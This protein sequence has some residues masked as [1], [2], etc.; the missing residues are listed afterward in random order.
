[1]SAPAG[2]QA[3][4][5]QQLKKPGF[6]AVVVVLILAEIVSAFELSMMYVTLPT[7]ITEFQVDA[8]TVAWVV[9][10]YLLVS[11][12]AGVMGGRFGDLYGR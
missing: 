9:T 11:A 10:A 2:R 7:L 3:T 8:N 4:L 1:M 12:S 6:A 5:L